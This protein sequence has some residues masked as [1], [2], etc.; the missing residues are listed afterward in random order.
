MKEQK[1]DPV[2]QANGGKVKN[3][4]LWRKFFH[5]I[6]LAKIPYIGLVIYFLLSLSTVYVAVKLP[7][8]ESDVF[9]GNASAANIAF[10]IGVELAT[11]LIAVV[12]ISS[13]GVI[14]GRI[15]RNFRN[16]IWQKIL[17]L[18][19]KYFDSVSANSLLSRITDDAESMKD[20]IMLILSEITGITTTVATITAMSTMNKGLA[21]MMA[22]FI[23]IFTF[24]GF[25]VGRIKMRVG[26][27][28]KFRMAGL[29]DYLSGQLARITVIKAYN[30]EDYEQERGEAAI[31]DYYIAQRK[32]QIADFLQST[33]AS[34]I[35]I[36]PD[37]ILILVGIYML[38][39][40]ALTPAGWIVFHAYANQVFS[41]FSEKITLWINIKT[42]QGHMNRLSEL[43]SVPEEGV[44]AYIKEEA[45]SGDIVFDG[46]SFSYDEREI[47]SG[48]TLTFP[49]NEFTAVFGPSGT[50][51]TTILKLIEQI[52]EPTGG[53]ILQNGHEIKEYKLENWRKQF[54]YVKQDTPMISGTIRD[55]ILYGVDAVLTDEQI[56]TAAKE[57]RAD[58]FIAD[59]PGGL[60]YDV[61]Q[62]GDKLSG[63]QKQKISLLRA[64]LQ[65]REYILL[66]EPT[67]S[68]DAISVQDVLDSI[69]QM[70]GKRTI[71]LVAHDD[72]LIR[73]AGHIIVVEDNTRVYEGTA[74][75]VSNV[76]GF[77]RDILKLGGKEDE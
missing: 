19:P 24:F 5:L 40:N 29:T 56:M 20:F 48:A 25:I 34:I 3:K 74:E 17:R 10:V 47:L 9:T 57:V 39:T 7:Q 41:F 18:E 54:S 70:I 28:V 73:D 31:M 36:V 69:K 44:R 6:R 33:I 63:G 61:G 22:V 67:A 35:H 15:D 62:F 75:E 8:V 64:F 45:E 71:I 51:K 13:M 55:N 58:A 60:D 66:D 2:M 53:R 49:K 50:G 42:Y 30:R 4:G 65:N 16:A 46:V 1:I 12:M 26:N 77:F 68:L 21:V 38:N 11:S 27:N 14:G 59:C 23:P 32:E 37:V 52:Y 43:F 72:K 76:S